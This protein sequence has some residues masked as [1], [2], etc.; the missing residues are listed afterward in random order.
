MA[1]GEAPSSHSANDAEHI[2][3]HLP[4]PQFRWSTIG[5]V[6]PICCGASLLG[7]G[8]NVLELLRLNNTN[9]D[10]HLQLTPAVL[11]TLTA[12]FNPDEIFRVK[13]LA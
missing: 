11:E 9:P 10:F 3:G 7:D 8:V 12:P 1:V 2:R 5:W 6:E 13:D 4:P